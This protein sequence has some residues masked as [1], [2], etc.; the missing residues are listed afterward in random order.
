MPSTN[1]HLKWAQGIERDIEPMLNADVLNWTAVAIF[2]RAMHYVQ[3][4]LVNAGY[5]QVNDHRKRNWLVNSDAQLRRVAP[6]YNRLF[7][8]GWNCRY[9]GMVPK[10]QV[11]MALKETDLPQ[12]RSCVL[13]YLT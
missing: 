5:P 7:D 13:P 4:Y 9:I 11:L 2:Y 6:A 3:A 10:R 12:V 1:D 8:I